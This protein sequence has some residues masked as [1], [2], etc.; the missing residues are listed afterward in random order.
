ML[1][2]CAQAR[3]KKGDQQKFEMSFWVTRKNSYAARRLRSLVVLDKYVLQSARRSERS[4]LRCAASGGALHL[5]RACENFN[6]NFRVSA[7]SF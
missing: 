2:R 6:F 1:V 5:S 4:H 3:L 7:S